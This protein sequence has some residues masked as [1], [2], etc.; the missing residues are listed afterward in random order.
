MTAVAANGGDVELA[1]DR[2]MARRLELLGA[3]LK[4]PDQGVYALGWLRRIGQ[5]LVWRPS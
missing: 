3:L 1:C 4:R 2:V 5:L